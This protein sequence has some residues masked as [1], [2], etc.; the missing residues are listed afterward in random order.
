MCGINLKTLFYYDYL[1]FS[2]SGTKTQNVSIAGKEKQ[3]RDQIFIWELMAT[4]FTSLVWIFETLS[5]EVSAVIGID[6]RRIYSQ[7]FHLYKWSRRGY[8]V[9]KC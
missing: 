7:V 1:G 6:E 4:R 3:K 9:S 2:R 8:F 5:C